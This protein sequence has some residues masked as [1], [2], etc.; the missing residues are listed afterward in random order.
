MVCLGI[1]FG[2]MA[3][4]SPRSLFLPASVIVGAVG[5]GNL[6]YYFIARRRAADRSV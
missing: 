5:M 4:V 1:A 6:I 3:F 2:V